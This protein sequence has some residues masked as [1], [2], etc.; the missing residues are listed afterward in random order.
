[1]SEITLPPLPD[2]LIAQR[3][4]ETEVRSLLKRYG[5]Q[6][7]TAAIE[8]DRQRRGE[9]V[10]YLD[11]GVGGY[12][13]VGTDLTDEQLAALPKGRHMLGI[14]G[15]YGVDGYMEVAPQP[16]QIPAGYKL[17]PIEPTIEQTFLGVAEW[18]IS[19]DPEEEV[20]RIYKAM[21]EAAPEVKTCQ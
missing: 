14:I 12:M 2:D 21:L 18:N 6:C 9:P 1:M 3:M 8:A 15:T 10:A 11:L 19:E 4:T 5:K 16:P 17:V 20:E 7:A 13:D